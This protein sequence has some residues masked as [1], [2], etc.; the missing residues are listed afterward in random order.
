MS[1]AEVHRME[2][3]DKVIY[4]NDAVD[5]ARPLIGWVALVETLVLVVRLKK[6]CLETQ[7]LSPVGTQCEPMGLMLRRLP[8]S[9]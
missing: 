4:L 7:V 1:K 6:V 3:L 5:E 9:H 2:K 8:F